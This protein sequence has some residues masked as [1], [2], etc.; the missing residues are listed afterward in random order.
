MAQQQTEPE[1]PEGKVPV[2]RVTTELIEVR[3]VVTDKKG[4]PVTDLTRDDFILLENKRPQEISLFSAV[5]V[6]ESRGAESSV[7]DRRPSRVAANRVADVTGPRVQ[8][9]GKPARTVMIFVDNLHISVS[10]LVRLKKDLNRF[11]DESLTDEDLVALTTTATSV[12]LAGQFTR[13]R[14]VLKYAIDKLRP[15][16]AVTGG[17]MFT[18]FLAAMIMRG[19][20]EAMEMGILML[21]MEGY[22][23][24]EELMT[25]DSLEGLTRSRAIRVLSEA[26]YR[27]AA[28]L[29]TLKTVA[30]SM[31]NLPGQR[32]ARSIFRRIYHD[33]FVGRPGHRR[34]SGGD[35]QS[36][37]LGGRDLFY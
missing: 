7:T 14:E 9:I 15:G 25:R 22:V 18:P 4:Q 31:A 12:G 36:N 24:D 3:V 8:A 10:N 33:G 26:S 34:A 17:G 5:R 32:F 30:E 11:I 19:D 35:Q 21:A 28:T 27:R 6:G 23:E 2:I 20:R 37:P 29:D 1:T 16:P 13:N